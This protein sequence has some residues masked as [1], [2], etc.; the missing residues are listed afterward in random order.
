MPLILPNIFLNFDSLILVRLMLLLSYRLSWHP[1]WNDFQHLQ[2]TLTI[3]HHYDYELSG[4]NL[5]AV[6]LPWILDLH[7]L[8]RL[9]LFHSTN[10]CTGFDC[11]SI[12]TASIP[13]GRIL[14]TA[15]FL[16]SLIYLSVFLFFVPNHSRSAP[17]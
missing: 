17:Y 11:L 10:Y 16:P 14:I 12:F 13:H 9:S 3:C 1:C 8:T 6:V 15:I 2:V 5:S 7:S 4:P